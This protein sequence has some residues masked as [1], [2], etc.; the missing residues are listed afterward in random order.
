MLRNQRAGSPVEWTIGQAGQAPDT[1]PARLVTPVEFG[2]DDRGRPGLVA[3]IV[4]LQKN[5]EGKEFLGERTVQAR[6]LFDRTYRVPE[7]DGTKDAPKP[8]AALITERQASV[9]EFLA[10]QAN[11]QTVEALGDLLDE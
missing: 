1:W 6:Y 8:V 4:T 2:T 3:T 5:L 7:L 11:G 9:K 10:N